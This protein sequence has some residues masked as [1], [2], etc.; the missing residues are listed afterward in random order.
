MDCLRRARKLGSDLLRNDS[1]FLEI[2]FG[3]GY[4]SPTFELLIT[5]LSLSVMQ[6]AKRY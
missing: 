1:I 5:L 4:A 3:E 2:T 6:L